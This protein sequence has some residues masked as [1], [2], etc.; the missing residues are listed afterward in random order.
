MKKIVLGI[1]IAM[2]LA[3]LTICGTSAAETLSG[4]E[5]IPVGGDFTLPLTGLTKGEKLNWS[6]DTEGGRLTFT[7]QN[8]TGD[9]Y[10]K[11]PANSDINEITIPEDGTYDLIWE[12]ND[13]GGSSTA[14]ITMNY[15]VEVINH[16]PTAL[17][18][19][20]VTSGKVP[21]HVKFTGSGDDVDGTI[22]DYDWDFG[23][24]T[25]S[26]LQ[27]PDHIFDT[28]DTYTVTLTVTDNDGNTD[29]DTL[30]ITVDPNPP[31]TAVAEAYVNGGEP[32]LEVH[33]DGSGSYDA[34]DGF[35]ASYLWEFD[36]GNDSTEMSPTYTFADE[37]VYEVTLTV[38][39]NQ[40][41]TG[42]DTITITVSIINLGPAAAGS[43]DK[44]SVPE[45]QTVT[46]TDA[47]TDADGTI[48]SWAWDFG[49]GTTSNDQHPTHDYDTVGTYTVVL[50]VEDDDGAIDTVDIPITVL[51]DSDGDSVPD[52]E[53][54][55]PNNAAE[56]NDNDDDDIGDNADPDDDNDGMS[57]DYEN[58]YEGLD[59]MVDDADQ[60]A[61]GDGAT[62]L[63]EFEAGTNPVDRFEKPAAE[64]EDEIS[65]STFIIL[66]VVVI[67]VV[68]L[69]LFLMRKGGGKPKGAPPE[70]P[71][72]DMGDEAPV[73]DYGEEPVEEVEVVDE[74]PGETYEEPS[75]EI[76][77]TYEE[78]S[79]ETPDEELD[80]ILEDSEEEKPEF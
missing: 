21:L 69:L 53:D 48:A 62:N 24:G 38:T 16:A 30:D 51:A 49:D 6:W 65:G 70:E 44:P 39:D 52:S 3:L 23:D 78:P 31:P 34:E 67:L 13:P 11:D 72:E 5:L 42:E 60:D 1:A 19:A 28:P 41:E 75:E 7:A 59:P 27:N 2:C 40:D 63:E 46:F 76:G 55:F 80:N 35:I 50:T 26:T 32:P 64:K 8:G 37:G 14:D 33:F 57:D 54:E 12:N 58:I 71:P 79:G 25:T 36:D 73:E 68:I 4:S 61:D 18:E 17:A 56:W 22:E 74:E 29:S 9:V 77:E 43:A 47:S 20:N 66:V 15:T 45:G 10:Y